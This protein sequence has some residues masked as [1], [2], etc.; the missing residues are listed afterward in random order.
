M[1]ASKFFQKANHFFTSN[2]YFMKHYFFLVLPLTLVFFGCQKE[3]VAPDASDIQMLNKKTESVHDISVTIQYNPSEQSEDFG[4]ILP[5]TFAGTRFSN[6]G[7]VSGSVGQIGNV[8]Q[9]N[10]SL[11]FPTMEIS[12]SGMEANMKGTGIFAAR[13]GSVAWYVVDLCLNAG[14]NIC[15]VKLNFASGT[16]KYLFCEGE[17][18][19]S[20]HVDPE[21]GVGTFTGTGQI[22]LK[23]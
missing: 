9:K 11:V 21:T 4:A 13:N 20:G 12:P 18:L 14:S 8:V 16:G 2:T 10:S 19:L 15:Q 23:K 3:S 1:V 6:G 7:F 22:I 5:S 17:V